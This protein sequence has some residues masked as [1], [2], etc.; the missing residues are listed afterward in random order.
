MCSVQIAATRRGNQ[1]QR[2]HLTSSLSPKRFKGLPSC[3]LYVLNHSRTSDTCSKSNLSQAMQDRANTRRFYSCFFHDDLSY[4][5]CRI[6]RSHCLLSIC[7]YPCNSEKD[8]TRSHP[9][10]SVDVLKAEQAYTPKMQAENKTLRV[11]VCVCRCLLFRRTEQTTTQTEYQGARTTLE[12]I[13]A[14]VTYLSWHQLLNI[15][16]VMKFVKHWVI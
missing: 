4:A 7:A 8:A 14:W 2:S 5:D 16:N 15:T 1:P 9:S 12:S 3:V 13:E 10:V 6:L 11:C